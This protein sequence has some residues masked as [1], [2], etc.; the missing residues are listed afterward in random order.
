MIEFAH[1]KVL[2]AAAEE[3]SFSRAAEQLHLSQSA[4]SQNI[5]ALE[6][7]LG[8]TLFLRKGRSVQLTE[9]GQAMVP[10]ARE[11]LHQV[12]LMT[13]T[14]NALDDK[15]VGDLELG[16]STTSGKYLLPGLAAAFRQAYPEV[17]LRVN[18]LSR[19]AVMERLLDE[20][21]ALGVVSKRLEHLPLEYQPFFEDRIILIAPRQH[22]WAEYGRALPADLPDQPLIMREPQAGTAEVV[23]EALAQHSLHP[24]MFNVVMEVGNAEAIAMAVEEGIGLA[25]V[26]ELVAARGLA[27]G[28]I[29][30]IEVAGLDL[31]RTIYLVRNTQAMFTR[32]HTAFWNF[33]QQRR[34]GVADLL[35]RKVAHHRQTP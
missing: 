12:R 7:A 16:C 35:A 10:L 21:V 30:Q 24:E 22:P 34:A 18:I 6:R 13:E 4:V 19:Q 11:A 14:L 25:F 9:A 31:R 33:L 15:V 2:L 32:A 3:E 23:W 1:L 5:H 29:R 27:L 26:S 20:R 8:V 28:H 17:H